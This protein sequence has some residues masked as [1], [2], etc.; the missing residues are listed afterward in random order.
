MKISSLVTLIISQVISFS[1]VLHAQ[2]ESK[3]VSRNILLSQ[4]LPSV[5]KI[6]KVEIQ[7]ITMNRRITD[8]PHRHPCPVFGQ[9]LE[10]QIVFQIKGKEEIV[11]K[12]GD[13]FFEPANTDILK[14]DNLGPEPAKF[15]AYYL[16]SGDDEALIEMIK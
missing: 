16:I 9:I 4:E 3:P 6:Q 14:F 5:E 1:V 13:A 8:I 2:E 11:L 12:K 10:G 15:V 7:E